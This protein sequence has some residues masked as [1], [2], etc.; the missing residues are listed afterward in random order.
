ML[1]IES[2]RDPFNLRRDSLKTSDTSDTSEPVFG[3]ALQ[4]SRLYAS[5]VM[6][7]NCDIRSCCKVP[8]IIAETSMFLEKKGTSTQPRLSN[9]SPISPGVDA[10]YIFWAGRSARRLKQLYNVFNSPP[11]Y[12]RDF[13]WTA[14]TAHDA[15]SLLLC[16]LVKLLEPIITFDFYDRFRDIRR[17]HLMSQWDTVC[18]KMELHHHKDKAVTALP[19]E[20]KATLRHILKLLALFASKSNLNRMT[21]AKLATQFQ[22]G[23]LAPP[24]DAMNIAATQ[25]CQQVLRLLIDGQGCITVSTTSPSD[26]LL[27]LTGWRSVLRNQRHRLLLKSA[28]MHSLAVRRL[29]CFNLP[30][31]DVFSGVMVSV[32]KVSAWGMGGFLLEC[33]RL[34]ELILILTKRLG[35]GFACSAVHENSL[36]SDDQRFVRRLPRHS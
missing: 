24:R 8:T 13:N 31:L 36:G 34:L 21:T 14:Y 5:V 1:Y 26:A 27:P 35:Q 12:G 30:N 3:V 18:G 2:D 20:N 6:D 33:F 22:P 29:L 10:K 32:W 16:Y 11:C 17:D 23:I 7:V 9:S 15:A 28:W 25:L 19:P 4:T